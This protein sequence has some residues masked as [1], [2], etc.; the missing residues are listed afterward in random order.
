M[1]RRRPEAP[2]D[3]LPVRVEAVPRRGLNRQEAARYV[4]ISAPKFDDL[5]RDGQMPQPFRIGS[6]TIY[7]LRKLD[8]AFDVLSA[9]EEV[10]S[11]ADW[12]EWSRSQP[13][14]P[15]GRQA[16]KQAGIDAHAAIIQARKDAR[17]RCPEPLMSE[18]YPG[19]H[20]VYTPDTLAEQWKCST[21]LIRNLVQRGELA[22][23][24]YG[25]KL[26]RITAGTVVAY[27][28]ANLVVAK[29]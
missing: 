12:E 28:S 6:R 17:R 13:E 18:E 8:A 4:G 9:P 23:V 10:D 15:K 20:H 19:Y 24:K 1:P 5:V 25:E 2:E 22:G 27:E 11:F 29:K 3:M 7:D 14:P 16:A 21:T 26:I